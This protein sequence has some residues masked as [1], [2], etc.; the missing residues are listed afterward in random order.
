MKIPIYGDYIV[1]ILLIVLQLLIFNLNKNMK[2]TIIFS[3]LLLMTVFSIAQNTDSIRYEYQNSAEKLLSTDGKLTIGGYGE[4]HYNQPFD[5]KVRSNGELDVHRMIMLLGYNFNS[6]T[7]FVSEIEYEHISE[8]FIEQAFL[9]YKINKSISFRGGLLLIPMGIINEYHEPTTF[10]GVERPLIDNKI[11]PSTWR[12]I[13]LGF[14]GTILPASLRYQIYLVNGFNGYNGTGTLNGKTGLRNGRQ[15]GAESYMSSPNFSGKIEFYGVR[16]LNI[17]LSSYYGKTQ[18]TLFDGI[19]KSDKTALAKADSSV[20]GV[21]M[22]GLDSRYN[23]KGIQLRAQLYYTSLSN[24][25]EYNTF[26]SSD[27]GSTM[28]GYYFEAGYNVFR[29]CEKVKTELIPFIRYEVYNSHN[30]VTGGLIKNKAYENEIITGGLS[31]KL[32]KGVVLKAD[33]QLLKSKADNSYSKVIN[34]GLGV[35]F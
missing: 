3:G 35:I 31:Y 1:H 14:N 22:L 25:N 34:A 6:R 19:E 21:S 4:V 30:S 12:E 13:G 7:Q 20:V 17:G 2:K 32:T 11:S 15:K 16:G 27:L 29:K 33:L 24:T 8:V 28:L 9:Q 5:S 26:A 23:I 18:S 10:N